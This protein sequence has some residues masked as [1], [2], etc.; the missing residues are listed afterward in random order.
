VQVPRAL[1]RG[2]LRVAIPLALVLVLG[3]AALG[4]LALGQARELDLKLEKISATVDANV[5]VPSQV[6][7]ELLRLSVALRTRPLDHEDVEL[8]RAF[9]TQ[10]MTELTRD[11]QRPVLALPELVDEAHRIERRWSQ[12]LSPQIASIVEQRAGEV[13]AE[14]LQGIAE[15][16]LDVNQMV[17]S[18]EIARR[19][20]AGVVRDSALDLLA[21]TRY[22]LFGVVASFVVLLGLLGIAVV[23]WRRFDRRR[24]EDTTALTV[25]NRELT[26]LSEV[27]ARTDNPVVITD[28]L[29]RTEWVNEAFVHVTG[30]PLHEVVGRTPGSVLQGPGT[31]EAT[32]DLLRERIRAG[33]PCEVEILNYTREGEPRWLHIAVTPVHDAQGA[34]TSFIA[35][36]RDVTERREFEA[37]LLRAK[38]AAE[39]TAHSKAA[40]LASMSHE[41]RTPLNAVVGATELLRTTSLSA[42]QE[43]YAHIVQDSSRMLLALI[44]D[45]LSYSALGSDTLE[46]HPGPVELVSLLENIVG[47]FEF[48]AHERGLDLE[49]HLD[50]GVPAAVLVDEFRLRQVLNNLVANAVRFTEQ[51][52]VRLLVGPGDLDAGS[53]PVRELCFAVVDT[54]VG[55]DPAHVDRLFEPF[56]QEHAG[57]HRRFGGTGLGLAICRRI[58]DG[59][60]G[61]IRV[62]SRP[63]AGSRFLV[64]LPLEVAPAGAIPEADGT[65]A[66]PPVPVVHGTS[67]PDGAVAC[68]RVLLVEDDPLNELI[69]V[70]LLSQVGPQPEVARDAERALE[71]LRG[72]P[73]DLVLT[74]IEL[75]G[76]DGEELVRTFGRETEPTERP[77]MV[78][79]TANALPGDRERL[80]DAGFDGYLSKPVSREGLLEA[81]Q[82]A[83]TRSRR[84]LEE[85]SAA[86]S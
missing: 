85:G 14:L 44:D 31:D 6:Q 42:D 65:S 80:L 28:A 51:G 11:S 55:I 34:L 3:L 5:R 76:M 24:Q 83:A 20:Q 35:V 1:P 68:V 75:P 49:V 78:A 7:R 86:P 84:R 4:A 37:E 79:F 69:A 25:A 57:V 10:R 41:I 29:G 60:G 59:M 50:E 23:L 81:L 2:L 82:A 74:D 71:L 43:R 17:A 58:V 22:L 39:D 54:G 26:K 63:G 21:R 19:L 48:E 66:A 72:R 77:W 38:E 16:E 47:M 46:F 56:T 61:T 53:G 40:F 13:P 70:E 12:E 64:A 18:T 45:I 73:F 30:Y 52:S 67:I 27:A 9:V 15:L 8:K 32:V 33:E 62:E 36:E